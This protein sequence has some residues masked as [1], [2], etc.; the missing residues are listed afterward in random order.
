MINRSLKLRMEKKCFSLASKGTR[1][2]MQWLLGKEQ[3]ITF[4]PRGWSADWSERWEAEFNEPTLVY[5]GFLWADIENLEEQLHRYHIKLCED[6]RVGW[7]AVGLTARC[8]GAG[9]FQP[10]TAARPHYGG[11]KG[12]YLL[13]GQRLLISVIRAHSALGNEEQLCSSIHRDQPTLGPVF[14]DPNL[15]VGLKG[16]RDFD[17]QKRGGWKKV[18]GALKFLFQR[19]AS[20]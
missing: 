6:F 11:P 20:T 4:L 18:T 7:S 2:A 8:E 16:P 15:E 19:E 9:S 13:S 1:Q 14:C 5:G 12:L 3:G 17:L 10:P